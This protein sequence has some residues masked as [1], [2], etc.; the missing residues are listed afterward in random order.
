[1]TIEEFEAFMS[2]GIAKAE[3]FRPIVERNE[4]GHCIEFF[5][6]NESFVGKWI[7]ERLTLYVGLE[8]GKVIGGIISG[9]DDFE[10]GGRQ[11]TDSRQAAGEWLPETDP[12]ILADCAEARAM[13]EVIAF[14]NEPYGPEDAAAADE[15]RRWLRLSG[16]DRKIAAAKAAI[17]GYDALI[18][19]PDAADAD[20]IRA[21]ILRDTERR[22]LAEYERARDELTGVGA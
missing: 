11:M 13:P 14:M 20:R 3:D 4:D 7:D 9:I 5:R 15:Q 2:I 1:M 17:E 21:M 10:G 22:N 6:T 19:R 18:S 12:D 8:S 16:Y